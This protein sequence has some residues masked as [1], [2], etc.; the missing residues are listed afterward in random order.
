M[1]IISILETEILS[2]QRYEVT[3]PRSEDMLALKKPKSL[4]NIMC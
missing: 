4:Q 2:A 3:Y 1:K